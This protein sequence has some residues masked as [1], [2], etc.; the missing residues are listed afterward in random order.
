MTNNLTPLPEGGNRSEGC[1]YEG[2]G[3]ESEGCECERV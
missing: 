3:C 2:E 1:G